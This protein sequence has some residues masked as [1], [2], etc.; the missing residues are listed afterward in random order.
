MSLD[1]KFAFICCQPGAE[2]AL[3]SD[4][5]REAPAWRFAFSRPG[6]LTFKWVDEATIPD[7]VQFRSVLARTFGWSIGTV[8][9]EDPAEL[10]SLAAE[11]LAALQLSALHVWRRQSR[12]PTSAFP[13]IWTPESTEI[14]EQIRLQLVERGVLANDVQLN[15]QANRGATVG[16]VVVMESNQLWVGWHTALA[17]GQ[18]WSGGVPSIELPERMISRAYLKL[19]EG[20]MWSEL[21]LDAGDRVIDLG[22]A[23]GGASQALLE[24]GAKVLG[25]DPAEMNPDV[26]NHPNFTHLR[27]R[28]SDVQRR[29]YRG[30]RW[31][32]A[33]ANVAPKHTLD[34]VESIVAHN[35]TD[36]EGMI[37]TLKL[38]DWRMVDSISEYIRRVQSWG[39]ESVRCRHL[40]SNHQEICLAALRR[41][42]M[43]RR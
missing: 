32:V 14:G 21:P 41:K 40:A 4:L 10:V 11:Q 37:L 39:F 2:I 12:A 13:K 29:V 6:F 8:R 20:L 19:K 7:K 1:P 16:D 36:V 38:S 31:L 22:S 43:R 17:F 9:H 26:L 18:R 15:S 3:K 33:D 5:A 23:P 24:C 35:A 25:V 34:T 28:G 42:N 27:K 30:Y